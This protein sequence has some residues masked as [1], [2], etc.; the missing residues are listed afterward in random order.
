VARFLWTIVYNV[1]LSVMGRF[2][3][4]VTYCL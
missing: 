1:P 2:R 4:R 3:D